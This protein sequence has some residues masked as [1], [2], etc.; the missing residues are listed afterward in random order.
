MVITPVASYAEDAPGAAGGGAVIGAGDTG[1]GGDAQ[2][3]GTGAPGLNGRAQRGTADGAA[4]ADDPSEA[5]AE[6]AAAEAPTDETPAIEEPAAEEPEMAAD[7]T[8][9]KAGALSAGDD[10][11]VEPMGDEVIEDEGDD[12]EPSEIIV[13]IKEDDEDVMFAESVDDT[14]KS[15]TDLGDGEEMVVIY[16]KGDVDDAIAAYESDPNVEYAERNIKI[17]LSYVPNDPQYSTQWALAQGVS[18]N[19]AQAWDL[20][21][22]R[23]GKTRVAV[24]D[25][26]FQLDHPDLKANFNTQYKYDATAVSGRDTDVSADP[27]QTDGTSHGCHVAGIVAANSNNGVGVAGTSNNKAEIVPIKVFDATGCHIDDLVR[28]IKYAIQT[29]CKII[30]MSLGY[31]PAIDGGESLTLRRVVYEATNAGILVIASGGN[32]NRTE[33]NYPSDYSNVLAV[34]WTDSSDVIS[35]HSDHNSRKDIAAPGVFIQSTMYGGGYG[36]MSGSSMS[37]PYVAGV[38]A[39]VMSANPSLPASKVAEILKGTAQDLGA[40]GR[41]DYYGYGLVDAKKAVEEALKYHVVTFKDY[42]GAVL[43]SQVVY[44]GKAATAPASPRRVGYTFTGWS[45]PFTRITSDLTVTAQ[46]KV[47]IYTVTFNNNGGPA[48]SV[49]SKSVRYGQALGTLPTIASKPGRTF[50]GWY[51]AASGGTQITASTIYK[52]VGN[53]TYYAHWKI[54]KNMWMQDGGKWY[55]L[56]ANGTPLVG[57]QTIDGQVRYLD[58]AQ[59]GAAPQGWFTHSNGKRYYF[60]WGSK[61]IFA[62]GLTEIGGRAYYFNSQGHLTSGW[63][64]VNGAVRYFDPAQGGAA[65]QGWFKHANGSTY[66]FW[67]GGK[68]IFATGY[69]NIGG[70]TYHFNNQGHLLKN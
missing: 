70:K 64:N 1:T 21:P 54:L 30:N 23:A 2:D 42:N 41:D 16:V 15:I 47:N 13:V 66:Y 4:A 6:G 43:S 35:P 60:W 18:T 7:E 65:P 31:Y 46:Y 39:L 34:T 63:Q 20:L 45:T 67:W 68:G 22:A 52:A 26:C 62:T 69:Q 40:P 27:G 33:L 28:G 53:T 10:P 14:I 36:Y 49:K 5:A 9:D 11:A 57:W 25:T 55:Y 37:S 17:E 51:T 56:G 8:V 19:I 48:P 24:M 59:G 38:A 50:L 3:P 32:K 12:E 58:P 61:G 29:N 44:Q